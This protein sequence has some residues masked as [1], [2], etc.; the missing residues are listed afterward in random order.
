MRFFLNRP[1]RPQER[2]PA[3]REP[4]Q[5]GGHQRETSGDAPKDNPFFSPRRL[6]PTHPRRSL[7]SPSVS[8]FSLPI[9]LEKKGQGTKGV[10]PQGI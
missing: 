2:P 4:E 1:D 9:L 3:F 6:S 10:F 5:G 7:S 8:P